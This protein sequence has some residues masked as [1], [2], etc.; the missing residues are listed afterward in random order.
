MRVIHT[1]NDVNLAWPVPGY[2]CP[3]ALLRAFEKGPAGTQQVRNAVA[4]AAQDKL[5]QPRNSLCC[6][7]C[8]YPATSPDAALEIDGRHFH[9]RSNPQGDTFE[10]R[11]FSAASCVRQGV[12]TTNYTWF[13]GY[14]WQI[15]NCANCMLQLGWVYSQAGA[16]A[17]YG[18]IADRLTHSHG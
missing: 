10:I 5:E 8:R 4:Q 16:A 14:A 3:D 15:A 11:L 18:L 7:R 2:P 12:A 17:F 1:A 6:A 13:S 9:V